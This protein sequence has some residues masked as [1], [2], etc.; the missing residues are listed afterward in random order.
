MKKLLSIAFLMVVCFSALANDYVVLAS[1]AVKAD[2]AWSKVV[3]ALAANH[4]NAQVFYF[5]ENPDECLAAVKAAYPRY[6][7]IV[8]APENIGRD[9]IMRVN[10][11]SRALDD[12]I[13]QDFFWG[14]ITG[15]DAN[16]AMEMVNNCVK[17]LVIESCVSTVM[18]TEDGKWFKK[19]AYT[20]DQNLGIVGYKDLTKGEPFHRVKVDKL[21]TAT[22]QRTPQE[23][24]D[25]LPIFYDMYK[26]VDPDLV[27]TASHASQSALEMP[28]SAGFIRCK[29]GKLYA[30]LPDGNKDL[31]QSGKRKLY[32]PIGNCLIGDVNNTNK[33]MVPTWTNSAKVCMFIGYVVS[34]WHGR[35]GWGMLKYFL[36]T[37]GRY[38][39]PE[40]FF[41]NQNDMMFQMNEWYPSLIRENYPHDGSQR[42]A[43]AVIEKAT[44]TKATND[45]IGF[46]YDRDVLALYGDPT[47]NVRLAD[48]PEESD[49]TVTSGYENGQYVITIKTGLNY[50]PRLISGNYF[51]TVHV[52][53]LPFSYIF[54]ERVKNPR[55]AAGQRM[56][57]AIDENFIL[58]YNNRFGPNNEY[59]IVLDVDK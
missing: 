24:T 1:N 56:K 26:D 43:A 30:Q 32:L 31:V 38:T 58:I 45:Q 21:V 7:G 27:I 16:N 34:T 12:D 13:Y 35:S 49:F 25:L 36:T 54:P 51:K 46:W 59:K 39:A 11:M 44:G 53:D 15:Y 17:P 55:L 5:N 57:V 14:V 10:R 40:C 47:W 33:S 4:N 52:L 8:D 3:S 29:D 28:F 2:A 20:D 6:V 19:Y 48:I 18:E 22:R 50:S 37:P 23:V 41:L 9:Y 42:D